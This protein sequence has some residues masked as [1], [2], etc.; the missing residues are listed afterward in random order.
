MDYFGSPDKVIAKENE[1]IDSG[2]A[3][4]VEQTS[5]SRGVMFDPNIRLAAG[6]DGKTFRD[7]VEEITT[8]LSKTKEERTALIQQ[9]VSEL[10][11]AILNAART[12]GFSGVDPIFEEDIRTILE[13]FE[14]KDPFAGRFKS[15]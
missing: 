9:E 8:D 11:S 3:S 15:L 13:E 6:S 4:R 2:V 10:R 5:A 7:I 1:A 14:E 12:Q